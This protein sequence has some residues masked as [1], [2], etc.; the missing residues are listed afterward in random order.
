[1]SLSLNGAAISRSHT[2][3]V[4][5]RLPQVRA[6]RFEDTAVKSPRDHNQIYLNLRS[7][8]WFA[9]TVSRPNEK[10]AASAP[11]ALHGRPCCKIA[12]VEKN[13]V[14]RTILDAS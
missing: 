10:T 7:R 2:W 12:Q 14:R 5:T 8:K 9:Y 6:A 11:N 4:N 3:R 13:P 1:M